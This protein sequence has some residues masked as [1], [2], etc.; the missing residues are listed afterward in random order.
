[1]VV[2]GNDGDSTMLMG[3]Y[4]TMGTEG[5]RGDVADFSR[6]RASACDTKLLAK[7]NNKNL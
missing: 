3:S 5:M 2:I 6:K 4:G 1:M 7:R